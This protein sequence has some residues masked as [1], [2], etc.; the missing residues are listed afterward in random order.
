MKVLITAGSTWVK[1]DEVR[2]LTNIF[3]GRT[4]L[5]LAKGFKEKGHKVTLVLNP[6]RIK[7]KIEGIKVIAFKYYDEFREKLVRDLEKN[8]YDLIIHSAAVSDYKLKRPFKAKLPSGRKELVLKL[9]PT[10][11]IIKKVRRLAKGAILI[12]FKLE[13]KRKDLI[14]RAYQNM[15]KNRSDFV[16][17]C[18]LE[19]LKGGFKGFV[20]GKNKKIIPVNSRQSLFNNLHST[21]KGGTK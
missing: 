16:V 9:V 10:E 18:S 13:A 14:K 20:V 11:K 8:S 19:E 17:A 12:Q 6:C 7:E 2:I 5:F 3:T 1:I 21:A 4:G 15:R